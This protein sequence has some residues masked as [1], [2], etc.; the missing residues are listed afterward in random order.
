MI[1]SKP[2]IEIELEPIEVAIRRE[3]TRL[4]DIEFDTGIMPSSWLV[5]YLVKER[6]RGVETSVV[7]L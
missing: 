7:N 4:Q 1:E 5:E 6:A 3:R 2:V